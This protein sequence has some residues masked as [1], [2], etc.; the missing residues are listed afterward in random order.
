MFPPLRWLLVFLG[1]LSASSYLQGAE[2]VEHEGARYHVFRVDRADWARLHLIW[3]DG[4]GR[5]LQD[6][7]GLRKHLAAQGKHFVFAMNAGIFKRGPTPSGLTICD[8]KVV[9][10]L[11]LEEG[12]GNFFLKPNGVFYLDDATGPGVMEANEFGKS[13]VTPR[14]ATQS[15]PLLLRKGVMHPAFNLNSP[16]KRLRNGVGVRAKDGQVIFV[17]SDREDS[18][19]GRVTFHQLSSLFLH[20]G[21]QDAL[22]LDGDISMML[23]NPPRDAGFASNTFAGMFYVTE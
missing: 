5:P 6:F 11:N 19:A 21:C 9:V 22:Y 1:C 14:L 20:L 23:V 17:M 3:T 10:P 15:G 16:N 8:G 12:E 13:G 2:T 7:N 4:D 18:V